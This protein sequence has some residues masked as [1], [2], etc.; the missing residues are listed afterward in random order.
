MQLGVAPFLLVGVLVAGCAA[1]PGPHGT[2]AGTA[3][4]GPTCPVVQDPPDPNCDDRPYVGKLVVM[5]SAATVA[6]QEFSTR[7]DGTFSVR[8]APGTYTIRSPVGQQMPYCANEG[9]I[10]VEADRTVEEDV[11]CD[12]GIR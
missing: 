3:M 1:S 12:T 7:S 6:V 5:D 11:Q 2:I 10:S 9:P 8:I 4:Q